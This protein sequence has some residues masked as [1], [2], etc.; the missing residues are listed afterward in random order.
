MFKQVARLRSLP[1]HALDGCGALSNLVFLYAYARVRAS[2]GVRAR[3]HLAVLTGTLVTISVL[4]GLTASLA[5]N[6]VQPA[7]A[8]ATAADTINFQARLESANGAIVPD[9][10]YNVEFKLYSGSSGGT[11][12]WT[13][14]Y[15][16]SSS[17]G[18]QIFDGYLTANLGSITS[19]PGTI[20]WGQQLWLTLNIGGTTTG[21]PSWDGEMNPRLLITAV[22]Y[23]YQAKNAT[24]LQTVN[25]SYTETLS[26]STPTNNDSITLPDASGTVCLQTAASCGFESTTGT[27]FIQNQNSSPQTANF[28]ISGTGTAATFNATSAITV[29]GSSGLTLGASGSSTGLLTFDNSSNSYVTTIKSAAQANNVALTIPADAH[30]TDTICLATL[31][32]C[33]AVGAASGDLAGTYPA[34]TIAKLQGSTL[35]ITSPASGQ[36][37]NYNGTAWV[38]TGSPALSGDLNISGTSTVGTLG[39]NG[40]TI[41]CSNSGEISSCGSSVGSGSYIYNSTS[42]QAAANFN[43]QSAAA[44][45]VGG[46]I[47]GASG[48]TADLLELQNSANTVLDSF[49]SSGQLTVGNANN[50]ATGSIY[51]D[52]NLHI[53]SNQSNLWIDG[54]NIVLNDQSAANDSVIVGGPGVS[55]QLQVYG[56]QFVKTST[57]ST[58]AFQVQ[59]ASGATILNTDTSNNAVTV[60]GG[61]NLAFVSAPTTGLTATPTSGSS[62]GIGTYYYVVTYVT[63]AGET[64]YSPLS[65]AT[66]TSGQQAM[67]LT[68]I[69]I[70][71]DPAVTARNIYR[72]DGPASRDP[73]KY[74]LVTTINDN[75]TTTYTDITPD[76][77]L[78]V[79]AK[80]INTTGGEL[81]VGGT[82]AL[83]MSG[84][85][86]TALGLQAFSSDTMGVGSFGTS[87]TAIGDMSLEQ[88]TTGY[89]NT[90]VGSFTLQSNT[91]GSYNTASGGSALTNNTTGSYN[92]A[93]GNLALVLNTEGSDNTASGNYAMQY[94]AAGSDNVA[95]GAYALLSNNSTAATL[96]TITGGSGY[97]DGTYN[98]VTLTYVS[99]KDPSPTPTADITVSGGAVTAVTLVSGG[100]GVDTTTVLS[101]NPS[102]I[103]GTGSGFSV[104]VASVTGGSNN[105]ALGY[106]AGYTSNFSYANTTGSNNTFLGY[107]SGPGTSTQLQ[108]AT[109][110]GTYSVVNASNAL[111]L[112][113]VSG[114]NGC[115]TSTLVGV[116]DSAP[117]AT[118]SV[119][120]GGQNAVVNIYGVGATTDYGVIQVSSQGSLANP[121]NRALQLQPNGGDVQ[122]GSSSGTNST[123][124]FAVQNASGTSALNVDTT[125]MTTTIQAGTDSATLGTQLMSSS[126]SFPA[127]SGW[128]SISGTGSS[129]TATHTNGG[130]TTS[131]SPTP[132]LSITSGD[133]YEVQYTVNNPNAGSTLDVTMGGQTVASYSFDNNN[134]YSFND[135]VIITASSTAN[136]AFTPSTGFT[137]TV[138]G[139]SVQQ[140]TT[141]AA[142]A[143]VVNNTSGN[144][145]LSVQASSSPTNLFIGVN[146]GISNTTG[147]Y[148]VALGGGTLESNTSGANDTAVGYD[149]L[150]LNTSGIQNTALGVN[151]LQSNTAGSYN[152]AVGMNALISN[153]IGIDNTAVGSTSLESNT[154][155]YDNSALGQLALQFNTT[156]AGNTAVGQ[157]ALEFNTTGYVDTA[158]GGGALQNNTTGIENVAVGNGTLGTNT[159]GTDNTAVGTWV[160]NLSTGSYNTGLGA[161]ALQGNTTGHDNTALGEYTLNVNTSGYENTAVGDSALFH[162]S[163][164]YSNA[165][166]GEGALYSN[167]TGSF[168]SALGYGAD[169]GAGNLQNASSIGAYTMV[170]ESNAI[171]I[172]CVNGVN[173]CPASTNVGIDNA[174]P[175]ASLSV[176]SSDGSAAVLNEYVNP[177]STN[178]D[179]GVIQVS[180]SGGLTNPSSRS[181]ALQ[182]NGGDVCV[183]M[184]TDGTCASTLGVGGSNT[185]SA[186]QVQ[187]TSG[188]SI[189]NADSTDQLIS[190]GSNTSAVGLE[191]NGISI[192]EATTNIITNPSFESGTSGWIS[193]WSGSLSQV[194]GGYFGGYA[195]Q[196]VTVGGNGKSDGASYQLPSGLATGTYTVSIYMKSPTQTPTIKLAFEGNLT[197]TNGGITCT[198]D[199]SWQRCVYTTTVSSW[200][201]GGSSSTKIDV[202]ENT[203]NATAQTYLVDGAQM[204]AGGTAT[205]YTDS[206]RS[207]GSALFRASTDSS[208]AFQVQD[209]GGTTLLG[210]DTASQLVSLG[211]STLYATSGSQTFSYTGSS[212]TFTVPAGVTSINVTL[213]G[214]QGGTGYG[215]GAGG[216]GGETTGTISV[217]PGEVLTI[218]AGGQGANGG[219]AGT[220][221]AGGYGGGGGTGASGTGYSTSGGGGGMSA[222]ETSGGTYLAIAG[223]GGGGAAAYA[224]I[225]GLGGGL[226]GGTTSGSGRN[227]GG[228]TQTAG[229]TVT[230]GNV[231]DTIAPTVGSAYQGGTGGSG[232]G[233]SGGGGGG[234]YY[235]GGGGD[236]ATAGGIGTGGG[237]S[238]LVPSGG[239]TT[240]GVQSGNGQVTI[241]Y[242]ANPENEP[243][244]VV[245]SVNKTV[246]IGVAGFSPDSQT[247]NYTGNTQTYTVPSGVISIDVTLYGA[248]G[249]SA[250]GG[251]VGGEGGK[252]TGTISVT[253][254]EVLTIITGGAGGNA[255]ASVGGTA[256]YGGGGTGNGS[257]TDAAG[258]GGG[259][260]LI[261][262]GTT[263]LAIAGGGGGAGGGPGV[264][265][266]GTGGGTTGGNGSSADE[267]GNIG[268]GG[269]QTAGG[270][271]YGSSANGSYEQG[272]NGNY[273]GPGSCGGGGGGG[274]GYYGGGGGAACAGGGGGSALVPSGGTSTNGVN[275]GNGQVTIQYTGYAPIPLITADSSSSSVTIQS[276]SATAL[277]VNNT[278]ASQVFN[279][280]TS[281]SVNADTLWVGQ[282]GQSSLAFVSDL[283]S[284]GYNSISQSGD[285]GLIF[286]NGSMNTGNLVIAPWANTAAGIRITNNGYVCIDIGSCSHALGVE[287]TGVASGGFSTG[288]P[289]MAEYIDASPGT[290][291]QDVVI[292]DPNNTEA[293][294]TTSTPYDPAVIGVIANGTSGFQMLNPHYGQ[295][296]NALTDQT[297]PNAKPM[298]VAGRVPV[299]V[300]G[301]GGPIKPGDYLTT[302]STPGYAMKADHAGPTIGK[303]LGF[304]SGTSSSGTGSVLVLV[305]PGYYGG[306]STAS[307]LQNG[308]NATL[309][310]LTV[311][312]TADF[313]DVNISGTT[314]LNNLTVT[315]SATIA[316]LTVIGTAEFQGD[317][318]V[319]G[320]IITGGQTP[321]AAAMV[322]A[323]AQ[324]VQGVTQNEGTCTV[325][326]NDTSGTIRLTTG[327]NNVISGAECTITFAKPFN[328][329]PRSMISALD[330][331][332]LQIGAYLSPNTTTMTLNLASTPAA[333]QTYNFNYWNPQ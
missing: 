200:G 290:T 144:P 61:L 224:Y 67:S 183:G 148:N 327:A 3:K 258:G 277:Q 158:L 223:G 266:G 65:S 304:F 60:T 73:N 193:Y 40:S 315:G 122:V 15:L 239:S 33:S 238:A 49:S 104:P 227:G 83:Q 311:G 163:T 141:N 259:Y 196:V 138:T 150:Q 118:L 329:T 194:S 174:S 228:G 114:T 305:T 70:S 332:S 135:D 189:L 128:T 48:Q 46:I 6:L 325:S 262:N 155:G 116:D 182:P 324:Q 153:T 137:G 283:G 93:N 37:L 210:I 103:G 249:G 206:S 295:K 303:A 156:G 32:N 45:D 81:S 1:Q 151:A 130:G 161:K 112:G 21:T 256:G 129:A 167:T 154:S 293:V 147:D 145:N 99:G 59:N 107:E 222:I 261:E 247:F 326:G 244:A 187:N 286:S 248:Q 68:N 251:N 91:T 108:N 16:N 139:V 77:S 75:T 271:S 58:T 12:L 44:G 229:G 82:V 90:G 213:D 39:T 143:L 125:D 19:F 31:S 209:T 186:F 27:D 43:I 307:Y 9:G 92:T 321:T 230:I 162:N 131:L 51:D 41:L 24:Q 235:G 207:A 111:T 8:N 278:S 47:Q 54:S 173:S 106:Q 166:V 105:T 333:D 246:D 79:Q 109:A 28:D 124:K 231:C 309:N 218:I 320:H 96:G 164:G 123:T 17:Q 78:G 289:D 188:T 233:Y 269:T 94:N 264:D 13:E 119:R 245:D 220:S 80:G 268:Y 297:D 98:N 276:N 291:A 181:L 20:N 69:P 126:E 204:E 175:D 170:N 201:T 221:A 38:N 4:A 202:I 317:V 35:T 171:S 273:G 323:G 308:G 240:S 120:T 257:G 328:S 102:S 5:A 110:I 208:T 71:S 52:G 115:T 211:S 172:G 34:P 274:G 284:G 7:R 215:G 292:A 29:Q 159:T 285:A 142:P 272:G 136:L 132:A 168:D 64:G 287:G 260:S 237:G 199:S 2:L 216:A 72:S 63:P 101:A 42:L 331:N 22:P 319:D 242:N 25:G 113:C 306:P 302:S 280:D 296:F 50:S 281:N 14:D 322:A 178:L 318:T 226:T 85:G 62:L 133:N 55:D 330:K 84:Y 299:K 236:C 97:T 234:G 179:Y 214:A 294:T 134:N 263:P 152:V 140:L 312:G 225:G 30:S 301:E 217:T 66:T 314:T 157:A 279:I 74:Y 176:G 243:L 195:M 11:A 18:I 23:A 26:F 121:N 203:D 255:S 275:T 127:T 169:V 36:V 265:T 253:P 288:T 232:A 89:S 53:V 95:L 190:L 313:A 180:N 241:Q 88:N 212:Q 149:S 270:A 282:Q 160:L 205:T 86:N 10:N 250:I 191:G 184:T 310:N 117:D 87:D 165:A 254:G 57:N 197:D 192:N 267:P 252:T 219:G 56:T 177:N 185:T 100:S 198:L 146:S 76:G 298:T 300:T 316:S